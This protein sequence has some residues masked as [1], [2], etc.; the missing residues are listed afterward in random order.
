MLFKIVVR[1]SVLNLIFIQIFINAFD[2]LNFRKYNDY[3]LKSAL[4]NR[5]YEEVKNCIDHWR[6]CGGQEGAVAPL[7]FF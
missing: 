3:G 4:C 7:T 5:N 1:L 2:I 6:N